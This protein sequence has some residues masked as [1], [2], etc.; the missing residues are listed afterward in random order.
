ML[1]QEEREFFERAEAKAAVLKQE[2]EGKLEI[3]PDTHT[4]YHGGFR[5]KVKVL[6]G[7]P[8]DAALIA[9]ANGW[10]ASFGGR[11]EGKYRVGGQR[12]A[13]V[14]VYTD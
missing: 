10:E 8:P 6:E 4:Q 12:Y 3:V 7:D 9:A 2:W 1:T 11:V 13:D 14:V 5:V